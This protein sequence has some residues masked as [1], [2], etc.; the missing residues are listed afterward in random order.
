MPARG[1]AVAFAERTPG[2][3]T[4]PMV[5]TEGYI[6]ER[7]WIRLRNDGS[8]TNYGLSRALGSFLA[9]RAAPC[10]AVLGTRFAGKSCLAV[11]GTGPTDYLTGADK[12]LLWLPL[13]HPL[14]A[15]LDTW[16][17]LH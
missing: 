13:L 9:R 5:F 8:P 7:A 14:G 16:W 11:D 4:P 3:I 1:T 12:K 15:S 10:G 17:R 2:W 6:I